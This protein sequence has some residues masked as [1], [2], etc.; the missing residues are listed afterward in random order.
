MVIEPAT[1]K[2]VAEPLVMM[3]ASAMTAKET[4][5]SLYASTE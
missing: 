2:I 1:V 5:H 4:T 3:V